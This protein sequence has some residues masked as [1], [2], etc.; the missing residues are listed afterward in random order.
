MTASKSLNFHFDAIPD[1]DISLPAQRL[2]NNE[3]VRITKLLYAYMAAKD[4]VDTAIE[5]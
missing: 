4:D 2:V 3:R 1:A 5:R